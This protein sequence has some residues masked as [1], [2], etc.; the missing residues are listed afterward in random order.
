MYKRSTFYT[1]LHTIYIN[2]LEER[3]M[4]L[5]ILL[6]SQLLISDGN[7]DYKSLAESSTITTIEKEDVLM[8]PSDFTN[9]MNKTKVVETTHR[10]NITSKASMQSFVKGLYTDLPKS[11]VLTSTKYTPQEL[12]DLLDEVK[13][14]ILADDLPNLHGLASY[15]EQII[16]KTLRLTDTSNKVY[17]AKHI[18]AGVDKFV[19]DLAPKLRGKTEKE[20]ILATYNYLFDNF[21][22]NANGVYTMRVG[23]IGNSSLAC[24]GFSY[25]ADKLLEANGIKSEIR[26]GDSHIWNV[27][28]LENGEQLTFDVTSDILLKNRYQTLGTSTEDH[29][30]AVNLIGFYN[31]KYGVTKYPHIKALPSNVWGK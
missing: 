4:L 31:A 9:I 22:Y 16:G 19:K 15:K 8:K 14:S 20:T 28:T 12:K 17:K 30:E 11:A 26:M 21:T 1:V 6:A 18:Q 2:R 3:S 13:K 24:N 29:I 23:N 5:T 10:M 7:V 25:L 27:L